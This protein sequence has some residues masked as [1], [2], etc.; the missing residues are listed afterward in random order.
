MSEINNQI[1]SSSSI[2]ISKLVPSTDSE[3]LIRYSSIPETEIACIL[4]AR[5]ILIVYIHPVS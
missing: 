1:I 5:D 2:Q 4:A 3:P